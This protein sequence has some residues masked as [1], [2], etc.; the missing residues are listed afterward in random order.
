ML[1]NSY[2]VNGEIRQGYLEWSDSRGADIAKIG[3]LSNCEGKEKYLRVYYTITDRST[4]QARNYNYKI[5]IEAVQ[6]NLGFGEV[7][8]FRCPSIY[9]RCRILYKAY[10]YERWQCMQAYD[11][12]IYYPLQ[13]CSKP[14]RYHKRYWKLEG[15]LFGGKRKRVNSTYRGKP[16]KTR[17]KLDRDLRAL[18]YNDKMRWSEFGVPK[19]MYMYVKAYGLCNR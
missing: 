1:A 3:F 16:T 13:Q 12:P 4:G 15:I 7:L 6:S 5:D 2:I 18:S 9:K 14:D 17:L 19:T 10:G 11:R 8:Y